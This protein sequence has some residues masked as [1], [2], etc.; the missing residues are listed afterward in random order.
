LPARN[1]RSIRIKAYEIVG[2]RSFQIAPKP[3]REGETYDDYIQCIASKKVRP[4]PG[5][6]WQPEEV[7]KLQALLDKGAGQLEIAA[8][9]Y[10]SR[11][12]LRQQITALRAREFKV[13]GPRPMEDNE[14]F[15]EY[16]ERN[17]AAAES[18]A[19]LISK[20]LPRQKQPNEECCR[21]RVPLNL[22]ALLG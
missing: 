11:Q 8:L 3:I 20:I 15:I 4:H 10:R 9:P 17:P 6:R 19:F 16:S 5:P 12:G 18:M 21:E 14:A 2:K 7:E 13:P 1:W 22:A